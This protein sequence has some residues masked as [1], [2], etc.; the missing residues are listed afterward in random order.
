[1]TTAPAPA[2]PPHRD[3]LHRSA[4]TLLGVGGG[5]AGGEIRDPET[6]ALLLDA[7]AA[8][9]SGVAVAVEA[10]KA[11]RAEIDRRRKEGLSLLD[12]ADAADAAHREAAGTGASKPPAPADR[13]ALAIRLGVLLNE[14]AEEVSRTRASSA[15]VDAAARM[16]ATEPTVRAALAAEAVTAADRARAALAEAE[17]ATAGALVA[18][19]VLSEAVYAGSG[20]PHALHDAARAADPAAL[21]R[22]GRSSTSPHLGD[23][24]PSPALLAAVAEVAVR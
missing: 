9:S 22:L 17:A 15:E 23:R 5:S 1:M 19:Q 10:H 14:A 21:A 8:H 18:W 16:A 13:E 6:P 2:L 11:R 24:I 4:W 20:D 3:P 7:L 12:T